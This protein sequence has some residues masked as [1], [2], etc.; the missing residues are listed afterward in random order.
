MG[1]N[2]SRPQGDSYLKEEKTRRKKLVRI[3]L[4]LI[5][6][7]AL[8]IVALQIYLG[9]TLN[10]SL[11]RTLDTF[12]LM[13]VTY[14]S[15]Q[16]SEIELNLTFFMRNPTEIPMSVE[17][18]DISFSVNTLDIGG[19]NVDTAQSLLPGDSTFFYALHY[20]NDANVLNSLRDETYSLK[21]AGTIS[22]Q[23][24]YLFLNSHKQRQVSIFENLAGLLQAK[25]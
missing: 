6:V 1:M 5:I 14:P 4:A 8:I 13:S 21:V 19:I 10:A 18:I 23:S 7:I 25:S 17:S 20:V 11:I 16:P 22:G 2:D 24:S 9:N 12:E 3:I 15:V